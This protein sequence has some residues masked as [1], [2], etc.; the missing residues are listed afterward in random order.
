MA[1][2]IGIINEVKYGQTKLLAKISDYKRNY[3]N[4]TQT[5][6]KH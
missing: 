1:I 2:P 4:C 5:Y 3:T 6:D